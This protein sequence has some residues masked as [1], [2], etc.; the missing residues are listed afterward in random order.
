MG[1]FFITGSSDG[2]GSLTARR[3]VA[4]GHQVV[5]HARN[6]ERARDASAA[7][8]GAEAVLVADLTSIDETK[9]LAA[10][11]DKLGPYD[12]IIHNA[13]VYVGM[14]SVPGKSGLPTLFA[15][16]TLA[17]YLLT[18]LMAKPKRLVYVSSGMHA[19][20]RPP[21]LHGKG[22][23]IL[24][25]GYSDSKLH[26]VMFAKAFARRWA[27]VGCY[28]VDPGWVPTNM[29][30]PSAPDRVDDG[31]D[32]YVMLALG[33]GEAGWSRGGYFF[34][35]RERQPSAVAGDVKLQDELLDELASISGVPVPT[36]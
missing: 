21:K 33:E 23:Q 28:S 25:T 29:G 20:G 35:S 11:A 6:A 12:A 26:N 22:K 32:T 4:K 16:N 14:E 1:R 27:Q 36:A 24:S 2:L 8:P 17:P 30:G 18:C 3:L 19:A 31:V 15:V 34:K 10:A 7:C 9:E 5:L 13:G